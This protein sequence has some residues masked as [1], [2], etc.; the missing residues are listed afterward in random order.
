LPNARGFPDGTGALSVSQVLRKQITIEKPSNITTE[1]W[2][3][4]IINFPFLQELS[5]NRSTHVGAVVNPGRTNQQISPYCVNIPDFPLVFG[6]L[7][8]LAMPVNFD[9]NDPTLSGTQ[10]LVNWKSLVPEPEFLDGDYR[11]TGMAFET[12][13]V[14]PELYKGGTINCWEVPMATPDSAVTARYAQVNAQGQVQY[15]NALGSVLFTDQFP[16][17]EAAAVIIP[18]STTL[19]AKGGCYVVSKMN[20]TTPSK[21][22]TGGKALFMRN[23]NGLKTMYTNSFAPASPIYETGWSS[24][25]M[26]VAYA[27]GPGQPY[28][29]QSIWTSN[30]APFN[31]HG[32]QHMGLS[33]TDKITITVKWIITRWPSPNQPNILV[34]SRMSPDYD[35]VAI[36]YYSRAMDS[37]RTGVPVRMNSIGDFFREVASTVGPIVGKALGS[38]PHPGVSMVGKFITGL[39]KPLEKVEKKIV[40][41]EKK[42][43]EEVKL[44][45]NKVK[46]KKK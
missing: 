19:D 39:T 36:E 25:I 1:G 22:D 18:N 38:A 37:I 17:T 27:S 45:K 40:K 11:V 32:A 9:I 26:G 34:L 24:Q 29:A 33:D 43:K 30:Y 4:H 46:N 7:T 12:R 3:L 21:M 5:V 13:S 42:I 8:T 31:L 44:L 14:G 23:D 20:T 15:D 10:P 16:T 41:E 35:P 28:Y 6:G 2:D